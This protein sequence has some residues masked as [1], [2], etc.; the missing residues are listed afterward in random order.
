MPIFSLLI[1]AFICFIAWLATRN[2]QM[3][4]GP[5]QNVVEMLVERSTTSSSASSASK[6]GPRYVPFLGTLFIYILVHEPVRA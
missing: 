4:P 3:I 2:A 6:H 1:G 5:L